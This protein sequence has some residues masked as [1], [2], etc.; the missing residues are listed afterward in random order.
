MTAKPLPD[1]TQLSTPVVKALSNS[2]DSLLV[3]NNSVI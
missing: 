2:P 3:S 1:L